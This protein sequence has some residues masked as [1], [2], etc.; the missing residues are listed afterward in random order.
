[1]KEFKEFALKGNLVDMSIAFV[2]G[3]A[4]SKVSSA[5]IDGMVMPL[6]GKLTSGQDFTK[7]TW[8]LQEQIVDAAGAV[9]QPLVEVKYGTFITEVLNFIIVAFVMFLIVKGINRMRKKEE[10]TPAAPPTPTADQT[11]LTE[12]RDLLKK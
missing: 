7:M 4:F 2:M 1:M 6:V 10:A 12:I 8:K 5:F 9:T 11:L 3:A